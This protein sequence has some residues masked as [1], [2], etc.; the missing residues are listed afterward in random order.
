MAKIFC[1]L[2]ILEI[3]AVALPAPAQT[4]IVFARDGSKVSLLM[5]A[6]SKNPDAVS[7]YNALNVPPEEANGK[8]TKKILFTDQDG[9]NAFDIV[10]AFS[11]IAPDTGSCVTVLHRARDVVM[12]PGNSSA[13]YQLK[14][15]D[16]QKVAALFIRDPKV[17]EIYH[18]GDRHFLIHVDPAA[19]K[20][21]TLT[22]EYR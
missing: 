22:V 6:L 2:L 8:L 1:V 20:P 13:S 9:V 18:S 10:C 19:D 16:A 17:S 4:Q 5:I 3:L 12:N 21:D 14:A 7:L 11:K 15:A